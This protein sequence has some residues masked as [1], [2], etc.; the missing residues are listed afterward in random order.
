MT[1]FRVSLGSKGTVVFYRQPR[2]QARR[3]SPE[4]RARGSENHSKRSRADALDRKERMEGPL[5]SRWPFCLYIPPPDLYKQ[6]DCSVRDV[7]DRDAVD[8]GFRL[9]IR[10]ES[11]EHLVKQVEAMRDEFVGH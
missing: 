5:R 7:L 8:R 6:E 2:R 10:P 9:G 11:I 4:G 3:E 1:K